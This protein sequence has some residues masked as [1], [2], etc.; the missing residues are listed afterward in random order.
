VGQQSH[1]MSRGLP[2]PSGRNVRKMALRTAQQGLCITLSIGVFGASGFALAADSA[3][4]DQ[5]FEDVT[6]MP[7]QDLD[8]VKGWI[9]SR[10][11]QVKT[12]YCY[13]DSYGRTAGQVASACA[14]PN[15]EKDATGGPAGLCYPK[16]PSGYAGVGPVC[17]QSCPSGFR[18]DGSF[19]AKP[20]SYTLRGSEYP[21]KFGD[22]FN[23]DRAR[24]RCTSAH[25]EGCQKLGEII[26]P[27]CKPG[28]RTI[29]LE[30][31][32]VCPPGFGT[33][34]GVSCTKKT[35]QRGA[36]VLS[37]CGAGL[38]R[39]ETGGP[40]G[41][42]Y[43]QCKPGFS[44]VGPVCWQACSNGLQDCGAG[45]ATSTSECAITTFDQVF[46]VVTLAANI[47][48]LG[49]SSGATAGAHAA[50]ET[51]T[52]GAKT[53][54]SGTK[55]GK[56][57]IKAVKFLATTAPET[58]NV[59][60]IK[61]VI[62]AKTGTTLRT[63]VTTGKVGLLAY[64]ATSDYSKAFAD[65]FVNQTSP[66]I[67]AEIDRRFNPVTAYQ[68]KR[69]WGLVQIS[70]MAVANKWQIAQNV[71]SAVSI[72]DITGVTGV[73]SAYAK[74]ICGVATPFPTLSQSYK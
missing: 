40:A 73:V 48:T 20:A 51:L 45:C 21:W 53:F 60:V 3:D 2:Q 19:C 63:I 56:A 25:S 55:T 62:S 24:A 44:G 1:V 50:G 58:K 31:S 46:S 66:E 28:F 30:C 13:R 26:Y 52:I 57:F 10:T 11:T 68:I 14:N 27:N 18:D 43:P 74:P 17:W 47:A 5:V 54:T 32:P 61:R 42:C 65:D 70:E 38:I 15:D 71:L 23:L 67:N 69:E 49:L 39:D 59:S 12:P 6:D 4:S 72:V 33:D 16:C 29:G 9:K 36:G 35:A 34:I 37:S 22:G 7:T 8:K 41:L 64:S